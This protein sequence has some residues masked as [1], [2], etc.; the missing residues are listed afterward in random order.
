MGGEGPA[1]RFSQETSDTA[2]WANR[3]GLKSLDE[4]ELEA[5]Y[6]KAK[7]F[8][9]H[10]GRVL[11][12][13][14]SWREEQD[15]TATLLLTFDKE[16]LNETVE[17]R[18]LLP[19]SFT[20]FLDIS[21]T[22][23]WNNMFKS[24]FHAKRYTRSSVDFFIDSV[25]PLSDIFYLLQTFLPGMLLIY[26]IDDTD[27]R[28]EQETVRVLPRPVWIEQHQDLLQMIFGEKRYD[29]LMGAAGDRA[30]GYKA[31]M[32]TSYD[33]YD[34]HGEDDELYYYT[35]RFGQ[36]VEK[37]YSECSLQCGYCGVCD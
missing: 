22:E 18:L 34:Y 36:R 37:D 35:N 8:I 4:A 30:K 23:T 15:P 32:I 11:V 27:E 21:K 2:F 20:S 7:D 6:N 3:T 1:V 16:Y 17:W 33:P 12:D 24:I 26:R 19:S 29:C 10:L 14:H 13:D 5:C 28:G 25:P 9:F 31:E